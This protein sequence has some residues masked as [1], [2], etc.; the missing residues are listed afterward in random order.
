M[1]EVD[2]I[3]ITEAAIAAEMQH[4][5]AA[6]RDEAWHAAAQA[7]VIRQLLL[8]EAA[9]QGHD[10]AAEEE[11]VAALIAA[12]V[13]VPEA[14]EATC[15]RWFAANGQRLRSPEAWHA[16]HI[17][18]AADPEE[19]AARAAAEAEAAAMIATLAE[20]PQRFEALAARSACP[21]REQG[22]DLGLVEPGS[23]V[24]EFEAALRSLTPG[25]LHPTP[26]ATRYGFHVLQLVRY[27]PGRDLPFEAVRE[28][29]AGW[30]RE[31]SFRT[32]IRQYISILAGRARIQGFA[33][34]GADGPLVQ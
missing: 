16:R 24:A 32:A 14:D 26:V 30:L 4:H 18:L 12:E 34:A 28:R 29:V 20:A 6:T 22:G 8:A 21:S 1:I 23:T 5:P 31:V 17:L 2:D 9:R 27:E 11:A 7:L 19:P 10:M 25:A 13:T 15:R 3:S 33:L